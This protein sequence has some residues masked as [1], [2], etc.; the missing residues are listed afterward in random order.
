MKL[1]EKKQPLLSGYKPEVG[2]M[3]ELDK[4]LASKHRLLI[5]MPYWAV[6]LGRA[7]I[8]YNASIVSHYQASPRR[9]HLEGSCHMF[10]HLK[11]RIKQKIVF[12]P[13]RAELD[14]S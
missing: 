13:T 4:D 9:G 10:G 2:L 3:E 8:L 14:E 1:A 12:D 5:G 7:N 6:Q 11:K